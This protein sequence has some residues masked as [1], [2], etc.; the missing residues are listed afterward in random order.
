MLYVCIKFAELKRLDILR[1][2]KLLRAS[3]IQIDTSLK[4]RKLIGRQ[5]AGG[6][7]KRDG[8]RSIRCKVRKT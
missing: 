7:K 6:N 2:D 5:P 4:L 3:C 8:R 1:G